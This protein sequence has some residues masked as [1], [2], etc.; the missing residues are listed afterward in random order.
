M[1]LIVRRPPTALAG[2]VRA[3]TYQ[4]GEQLETSRERILP[5]AAVDLWVNLNQDAFRSYSGADCLTVHSAPGA[6]VAGPFDRAS[7]IEFEEGRAHVSVSFTLGGAPA[8]FAAPLS[9]TRNEMVPL[10]ELWGRDGG[11]LRERLLEARTP[12]D[13]LDVMEEVLL[14]HVVGRLRP[15]PAVLF[16]ASAFDAGASVSA[17]SSELGML[18]KTFRRR[19]LTNV[20]LTPKRFARVRRLQRV[21]RSIQAESRVSWAAVAA[22][23]GFFDQAHL[24]DEFRDLVGVTPTEYLQQRIDGPN[25][26]RLP[27][28]AVTE[29]DTVK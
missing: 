14:R 27:A 19:F 9:V 15:D 24:V 8:L 5:G 20:G 25:H 12:N 11:C 28:S 18:P 22:E 13:K 29:G 1:A 6:I 23:H 4:S 3:I 26:L 16:A 10:Q 7:V 17:V 21:V 2:V